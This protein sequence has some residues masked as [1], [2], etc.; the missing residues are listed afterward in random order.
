GK[1]PTAKRL[2]ETAWR[3]ASQSRADQKFANRMRARPELMEDA[4]LRASSAGSANRPEGRGQL[5]CSSLPRP[6]N[7]EASAAGRGRPEARPRAT[8]TKL[9]I[10]AL[11]V[12]QFPPGVQ[13]TGPAVA[14]RGSS[15]ISPKVL[16]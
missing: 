12:Q 14:T 16:S 1:I 13:W 4:R 9:P 7:K 5:G 10:F 8:S 15:L 3:S 6:R 2:Q 11:R